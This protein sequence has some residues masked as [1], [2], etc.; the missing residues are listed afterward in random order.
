MEET[1]TAPAKAKRTRATRSDEVRQERRRKPGSTVDYGVKLG[2]PEEHLDRN[3][4]EYRWANDTGNR[5]AGLKADDWDPAPIEGRSVEK[6][7][8]GTD[9][10]KPNS[11]VLLRK[12]KDW[13]D[14]DQKEKRKPLDE[15]DKA[16]KRGTAHRAESDLSG[17]TSYTPNGAN[18][19]E[20]S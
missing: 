4:Y 16:I 1:I 7:H 2:V 19:I 8:V 3:T 12:R 13:Y 11:A 10:G 18:T 9:S 6:R 17:D 15:M 20:R 5:V 14:A